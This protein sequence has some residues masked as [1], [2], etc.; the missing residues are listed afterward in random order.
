MSDEHLKRF[1]TGLAVLA[2]VAVPVLVFSCMLHMFGG[3]MWIVVM[4][5][6]VSYLFG[7]GMRSYSDEHD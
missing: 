1:L 4:V 7:A 5:V 3:V 2:A 6:G